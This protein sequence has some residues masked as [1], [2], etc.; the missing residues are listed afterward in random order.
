[1][2]AGSLPA[3]VFI[4]QPPG[5][6]G[7]SENM[8][9]Y[10]IYLSDAPHDPLKGIFSNKTEAREAAKLYIKQWKLKSKIVSIVEK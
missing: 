7:E 10:Y 3:A 6:R 1:M 5:I 8:K 9:T 2:H 4:S